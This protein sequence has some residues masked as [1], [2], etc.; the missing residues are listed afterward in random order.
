[1]PLGQLTAA[2]AQGDWH[3]SNDCHRILLASFP[4]GPPLACFLHLK[5]YYNTQKQNSFRHLHLVKNLHLIYY[6]FHTS[7]VPL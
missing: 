4:R 2:L 7:L 3:Y 5:D 6:F 1:M